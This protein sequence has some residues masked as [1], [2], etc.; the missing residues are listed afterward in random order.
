L[1]A[2][3]PLHERW[4]RSCDPV[5]AMRPKLADTAPGTVEAPVERLRAELERLGLP[6]SQAA[7]LAAQLVELASRR[8]EPEVRALL[9]G[10]VLGQR[11]ARAGGPSG[12]ELSRILEDFASE[13]KKLDEGL[14]VLG[15]FLTRLRG[16][17]ESEP[18]TLH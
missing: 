2:L 18:R 8:P 10:V 1:P 11:A 14:R 13:L 9:D 3:L 6:P 4:H 12:T 7:P 15:A 5:R 16:P 17:E